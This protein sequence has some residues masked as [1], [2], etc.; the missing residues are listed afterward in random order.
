MPPP[1]TFIKKEPI[2]VFNPTDLSKKDL[3]W[4]LHNTD[5]IIVYTD[6]T[7]TS[8]LA[9]D[10]ENL[11]ISLNKTYVECKFANNQLMKSKS[12]TGVKYFHLGYYLDEDNR[13]I[14]LTFKTLKKLTNVKHRVFRFKSTAEPF[15]AINLEQLKLSIFKKKNPLHTVDVYFESIIRLALINYSHEWDQA[16]NLYLRNGDFYFA[17]LL[18]NTYWQR[19]GSVNPAM[20]DLL[21][22]LSPANRDTFI[23]PPATMLVAIENV[24]QKVEDLDRCFLIAAPRMEEKM[25]LWR[26]MTIKYP[27][28][29]VGDTYICPNYISCSINIKTAVAFGGILYKLK[30][31][32]G[33]P[34]VDMLNNTV[35]SHE[36]EIL[37]PRGLKLTYLED[38]HITY[39]GK[40]YDFVHL[41]ID[42]AQPD[43][44]NIQTGCFPMRVAE[45]APVKIITPDMAAKVSKVSKAPKLTNKIKPKK[46]EPSVAEKKNACLKKGKDFNPTT[47]KCVMKCKSADFERNASFRCVK[48]CPARN[49]D[50]NPLTKKCIQKCKPE[51][52]R[53]ADFKCI[54]KKL[55]DFI[56]TECEDMEATLR[57]GRRIGSGGYGAIYQLPDGTLVKKS[58]N[59][60]NETAAEMKDCLEG[61][62]CKNELLLEG[63]IMRALG[64]LKCEH[65]VQFKNLYKCGTEYYIQMENLENSMPFS[66]YIKK[67]TLTS[68]ERLSILFQITY[69][70]FLANTRLRFVHGDLIGKNVMIQKV[71]RKI[72]RYTAGG[73]SFKHDNFGLR[74]VIIDFG[75]SR[76]KYKGIPLYQTY[77]NPED[78]R[79]HAERSNGTADIC[80]IYSNPNFKGDLDFTKCLIG[81]RTLAA[82]L[83]KCKARGWSHVAIPPF[84][85]R[86][87]A[88]DV[89]KSN[90]F[91][92]LKERSEPLPGSPSY[93]PTSPSYSPTSPSYSPTSPS[94][95]S[96]PINVLV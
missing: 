53:N 38:G 65:F 27:L 12:S 21:Y 22:T 92:S 78:F 90:L 89:L 74:V 85:S 68:Q 75:F 45:V 96:S 77:R 37:L 26:G 44:F 72:K 60:Q 67:H 93:S 94:Y 47:K 79:T 4:L 36:K 73:Q 10:L 82:V 46:P 17:T 55:K 48:T 9:L 62:G 13:D 11:H 35:H 69:A 31:K 14:L 24:K 91:D 63:L 59:P 39:K 2:D 23:I 33:V 40:M 20:I 6:E 49:K 30:I 80:K 56:V 25:I 18:F 66:D 58:L 81:K 42:L 64:E 88:L 1:I 3:N 52:V 54:P 76:L 16:M 61:V 34:F 43:Q 57:E 8:F 5:K 41:E 28:D 19:Y 71:P 84:P 15:P 87:K 51:K 32:N 83:L 29:A 50:Y 95:D 70:L 7:R 86:F